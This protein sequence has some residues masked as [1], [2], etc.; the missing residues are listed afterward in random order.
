MHQIKNNEALII[1]TSTCLKVE[2]QVQ[3]LWIKVI[4]NILVSTTIK[5]ETI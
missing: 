1:T 5:N 3:S 4:M 2:F